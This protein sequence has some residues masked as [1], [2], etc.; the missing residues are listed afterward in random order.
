MRRACFGAS[1]AL[2]FAGAASAVDL[3]DEARLAAQV[4]DT[5]CRA[6]EVASV[7]ERTTVTCK[8]KSGSADL[9]DDPGC[10]TAVEPSVKRLAKMKNFKVLVQGFADRNGGAEK[11]KQLSFDRAASLRKYLVDSGV[12]LDRIGVAGF[13]SDPAFF[14]CDDATKACDERNRRIEVIEYLCGKPKADAASGT[15]ASSG[16]AR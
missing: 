11:N 7:K 12:T 10:L 1:L 4:K 6:G 5:T 15:K 13:G 3:P 2:F 14:I 16:K 9:A 8:F